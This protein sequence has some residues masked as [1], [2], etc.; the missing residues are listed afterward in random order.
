MLCSD[1][2]GINLRSDKAHTNSNPDRRVCEFRRLLRADSSMGFGS[3]VRVRRGGERLG[4]GRPYGIRAIR[5]RNFFIKGLMAATAALI[6][7]AFMK[8]G[9]KP[10]LPGF[11]VSGLTAELIMVGGY[12]LYEATLL[13]YGFFGAL[14]GIPGNCLQGGFGLAIGVIL[15]Q[16]IAKTGVLK[17]LRSYVM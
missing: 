10:R 17:K 14:E 12:Y 3:R 5:S 2:C 4:V 1:V 9:G 7:T 8:R 11:V 15:V 13:G 6:I 16:V